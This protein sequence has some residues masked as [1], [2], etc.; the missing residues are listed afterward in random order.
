[1]T[2]AVVGAVACTGRVDLGGPNDT[3][4][5]GTAD[6]VVQPDGGD[7]ADG[8]TDPDGGDRPDSGFLPD[9]GQPIEAGPDGGVSLT[10]VGTPTA[11]TPLASEITPSSTEAQFRALVV[12]Q[13]VQY[14]GRCLRDDEVGI[15]LTS[16]SKVFPL[17]RLGDG[18]VA[19]LAQSGTWSL[20]VD[21]QG[22][23]LYLFIAG[24]QDS[25]PTFFSG[26]AAMHALFSP[27]FTNYARV[28]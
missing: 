13:W 22:A 24:V 26:G 18:T 28:P 8:G 6:V 3:H 17:A 21:S 16:D 9:S 14:E 5:A 4:D 27:W 15:E 2:G 12:G 1:M 25:P 7:L 10:C 19:R 23:P 11:R 20:T